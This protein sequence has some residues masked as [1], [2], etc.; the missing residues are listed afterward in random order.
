MTV[1]R[2]VASV[3][4]VVILSFVLLSCGKSAPEKQLTDRVPIEVLFG[5]GERVN[6]LLSPDGE[7]LAYLAKDFGT[8]NIFV[9]D[10]DD[11]TN[12]TQLTFD[13]LYGI[14]RF[15]W[16]A[17]SRK[18]LY[19]RDSAGNGTTR[20]FDVEVANGKTRDLTPFD[21]IRAQII[22]VDNKYPDNALF[23]MNLDNPRA[24][25]V[26]DLQVTEGDFKLV[27]ENPGNVIGWLADTEL[28]IKG[29]IRIGDN[30][31]YEFMYADDKTNE[32]KNAITWN[33]NEMMDSSPIRFSADNKYAYALDARDANTG[34]LVKVELATGKVEV[35]AEDSIYNVK[36]AIFHPVTN[37]IEAVTFDGQ[38]EYTQVLD[39]EFG[40]HL[41]VIQNIHEGDFFISSRSKD[42]KKW[43]IGYKLDN[44]PVPFYLYETDSKEAG[45][46]F[47]H[48]SELGKYEL[49]K[50]EPIEFQA[51]D[52]LTIHGYIS[53]PPGL[54]R[55]GLPMVVFVHDGPWLRDTWGYRPEVQ[56]LTDMGYVCLQVNY[57]G[58]T[59]Y[60]KKFRQAGI[61]QW[62]AQMQDDLVDGV[63]WA[64]EQKYA[65]PNR[66]AIL[67]Q[68]YGGYAALMAAAKHGDTFAAAV[69]ISG[70]TSIPALMASIP[71][72]NTY[73][74]LL[75]Y[76]RVGNPDHEMEFLES[77]SPNQYFDDIS[78]PMF[79][80][81]GMLDGRV[82]MDDVTKLKES[83]ENRDVP[84]EVLLFDNEASG[85]VQTSNRLLFYESAEQ[86][87][88]THVK[89]AEKTETRI[90]MK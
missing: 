77:I 58:S 11:P 60:G 35:V 87:L 51:R 65:D 68:G 47:T 55:E 4:V 24:Y 50:I 7:N 8:M 16:A 69:D 2:S 78:I 32:W 18:I 75:Y 15:I 19:L 85:L 12:G 73:T 34:R 88:D 76:N 81:Y 86:F 17:D 25:N 54:G 64:I 40:E 43:L 74:K 23:A 13:S 84:N 9:A 31:T 6:P 1:F 53:F 63:N 14:H 71:D 37:E 5:T 10:I 83:L 42:N 62:G 33:M 72:Y 59:G 28:R 38:R 49:S 36:G 26:F 46:L 20:L 39:S 41:T 89:H 22:G 48:D 52:G 27:A 90:T 82:P 56:W 45:L 61:R 79:L 3:V 70:Y 80:V 57:R 44:G 29:C 66:V 21:N 67:G 30:G